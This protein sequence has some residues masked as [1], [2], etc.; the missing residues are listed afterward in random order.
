MHPRRLWIEDKTLCNAQLIDA[1]F[2]APG[3]RSRNGYRQVEQFQTTVWCC[4]LGRDNARSCDFQA[5]RRYLPLEQRWVVETS[6]EHSPHNEHEIRGLPAITIRRIDDYFKSCP[7]AKLQEVKTHL[8]NLH[9]TCFNEKRKIQQHWSYLKSRDSNAQPDQYTL[10]DLHN[11]ATSVTFD[12]HMVCMDDLPLFRLVEYSISAH[13]E[14]MRGRVDLVFTTSRLLNILSQ[15]ETVYIDG[16]FIASIPCHVLS[17]NV[18]DGKRKIHTI[19]E[20]IATREDRVAYESMVDTV[21]KWMQDKLSRPF[22]PKYVVCDGL[23]YISSIFSTSIRVMCFWHMTRQVSTRVSNDDKALLGWQLRSL[24]A[25]ATPGMYSACIEQFR[26]FWAERDNEFLQYFLSVYL[27]GELSNWC[28]ATIPRTDQ[29]LSCVNNASESANSKF[30]RSARAPIHFKSLSSLIPFVIRCLTMESELRS[31]NR[32]CV[33]Y[34][35]YH[36]LISRSL[37]L[38]ERLP[39]TTGWLPT[40]F[41]RNWIPWVGLYRI[42]N[43]ARFSFSTG[44]AWHR[45]RT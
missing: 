27:R 19:C 29:L 24:R 33:C 35:L 22:A 26:A 20:C 28:R 8:L 37:A 4:T 18:L 42:R 17:I 21:K 43:Q 11:I 34:P 40:R 32:P 14:R 15:A 23:S 41:Y 16:T 6:G 25:C 10:A 7:D 44:H 30:K 2:S 9:D 13:D 39:Q 38:P 5:R 45:P 36:I 31:P 12:P 3:W 1:F